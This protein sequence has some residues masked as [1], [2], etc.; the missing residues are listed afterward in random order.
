[1]SLPIPVLVRAGVD[2]LVEH[3]VLHLVSLC[4]RRLGVAGVVLGEVGKVAVVVV[5]VRLGLGLHQIQPGVV[6]G[7]AWRVQLGEIVR[8]HI[9]HRVMEVLGSVGLLR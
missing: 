5:G 3:G 2:V 8:G 6:V 4:R 9:V 1:M 7:L